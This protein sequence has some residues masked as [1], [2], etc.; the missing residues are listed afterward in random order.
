MFADL[1]TDL[2]AAACQ[3]GSEQLVA[4]AE[5]GP[6]FQW[7]VYRSIPLLHA[8][9]REA[10]HRSL[11]GGLPL[12][13]AQRVLSASAKGAA[14]MRPR[15]GHELEEASAEWMRTGKRP[16]QRRWPG[17]ACCG[18]RLL[19]SGPARSSPAAWDARSCHPDASSCVPHHAHHQHAADHARPCPP[20]P[21]LQ[22]RAC[23]TPPSPRRPCCTPTQPPAP[24]ST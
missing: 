5:A 17:H 14:A 16:A 15:L 2:A 23:A 24:P 12:P 22:P 18:P 3:L 1:A 19:R 10:V 11:A 20:P 13:V 9:S 7:P 8:V 21:P 4:V 6:A